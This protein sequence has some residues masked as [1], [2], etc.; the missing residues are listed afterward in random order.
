MTSVAGCRAALQHTARTLGGILQ[1]QNS[2]AA[3]GDTEGTEPEPLSSSALCQGDAARGR[4]RALGVCRGTNMWLGSAALCFCLLPKSSVYRSER[5]MSRLSL[6][7]MLALFS[8][9]SQ[10]DSVLLLNKYLLNLLLTTFQL[11]RLG[12]T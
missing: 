9:Q 6:A 11:I 10:L 1:K 8:L 4:G 5:R 3:V 12:I 7:C 2:T